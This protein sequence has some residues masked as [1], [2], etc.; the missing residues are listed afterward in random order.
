[1][2]L[3]RLCDKKKELKESHIIPYSIIKWELKKRESY[4]RNLLTPN[5]RHQDGIKKYLLCA[6]CEELFSKKEKI[7][8]DKIFHPRVKNDQLTFDYDD[9]LYY[10]L[11]SILWRLLVIEE[12]KNSFNGNDFKVQLKKARQDWKEF[13]FDNKQIKKFKEIHFMVIPRQKITKIKSFID[14]DLR[15][16]LMKSLDMAILTFNNRCAVYAKFNTFLIF[17]PITPFKN[18]EWKKTKVVNGKGKIIQPQETYDIAIWQHLI[19]RAVE[20]ANLLRLG[21][22]HKQAEKVYKHVENYHRKN[23]DNDYR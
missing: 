6:D 22:S 13:L 12:E 1:M 15:N 14:F 16:Y 5:K 7:F 4:L 17:A 9:W 19:Q 2:E 11:I 20:A 23:K 8:A 18:K 3:C 10:F 21:M